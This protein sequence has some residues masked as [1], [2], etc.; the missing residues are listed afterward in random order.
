MTRTRTEPPVTSRRP[1]RTAAWLAAA[2]GG[3][4]AFVLAASALGPIAYVDR[5]TVENTTPFR[6]NVALAA[7]GRP[8][9]LD[10]GTAPREGTLVLQE[11]A[12]PGS[13]WIVH[14][15]YAGTSA[16]DLVVTRSSLSDAGWRLEIPPS[17]GDRLRAQGFVPSTH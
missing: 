4:A 8:G 9:V 5:L 15:S 17:F 10:L 13:R 1:T 11:V 12:D 3:L 2:A 16:G 6:V 7:E 14:V